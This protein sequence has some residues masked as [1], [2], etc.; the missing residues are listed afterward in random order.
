MEVAYQV[1]QVVMR[2][3]LDLQQQWQ[4]QLEQFR[5]A[6]DAGFDTYCWAHHYLIDPFQHFQPF[7]VLARLA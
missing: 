6:R 4:D 5:A 7:P 3:T 2:G 1:G